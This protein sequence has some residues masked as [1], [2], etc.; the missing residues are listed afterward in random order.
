MQLHLPELPNLRH[1]RLNS[2]SNA[3][4]SPNPANHPVMKSLTGAPVFKPA[5]ISTDAGR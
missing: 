2:I 1:R 4:K 5:T 3:P